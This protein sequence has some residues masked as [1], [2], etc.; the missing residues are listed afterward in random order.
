M[1]QLGAH[2]RKACNSGL[3]FFNY[4][5]LSVRAPLPL[6]LV[7]YFPQG[8]FVGRDRIYFRARQKK[9]IGT[10]GDCDTRGLSAAARM[11]LI[12]FPSLSAEPY[13]H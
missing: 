2:L 3:F 4:G 9:Q 8:Q 5:N 11:L 6:C 7:L 10:V 1:A 13:C 12:S